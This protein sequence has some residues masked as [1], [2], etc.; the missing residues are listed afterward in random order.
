MVKELKGIN[1]TNEMIDYTQNNLEEVFFRLDLPHREPLGVGPQR[2]AAPDG[3]PGLCGQRRGPPPP[4]NRVMR[5][6]CGYWTQVQMVP[7]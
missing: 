7:L 5:R 4:R 3:I 1:V 6:V 2:L